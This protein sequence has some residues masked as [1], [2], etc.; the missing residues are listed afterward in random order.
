M[1]AGSKP[2]TNMN[3]DAITTRYGTELRAFINKVGVNLRAVGCIKN[4]LSAQLAHKMDLALTI[5]NV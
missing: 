3:M 5:H 1:R 2:V 4:V